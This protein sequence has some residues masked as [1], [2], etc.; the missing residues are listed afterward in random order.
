MTTHVG[1]VVASKDGEHVVDDRGGEVGSLWR[2][3]FGKKTVSV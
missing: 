3:R 1:R 2:R